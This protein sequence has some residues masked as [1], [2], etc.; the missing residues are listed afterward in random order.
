MRES[1]FK[2]RFRMDE[3]QIKGPSRELARLQTDKERIDAENK[4]WMGNL[5]NFDNQPVCTFCGKTFERRAVLTSHMNNC[6]KLKT[7][8][9]TKKTDLNKIKEKLNQ[10]DET[11]TNSNDSNLNKE[12]LIENI[13]ISE[14]NSCEIVEPVVI[15]KSIKIETET[16]SRKRKRNKT[17][18]IVFPSPYE[19]EEEAYWSLDETGTL[20]V[21]KFIKE[22]V[23]PIEKVETKVPVQKKDTKIKQPKDEENEI[24]CIICD[25]K[26]GGLSN[27]KRHV[28]MFHYRQKKFACK[29]CEYRNFRKFDIIYH[30]QNTHAMNQE[31][32]ELNEFIIE[33]NDEESKEDEEKKEIILNDV[34]KDLELKKEIEKKRKEIPIK[35]PVRQKRKYVRKSLPIKPEIV[36]VKEIVKTIIP[37]KVEEP[38]PP[39]Q[40]KPTTEFSPPSSESGSKRPIRNRIKAIDKDFVYDLSNLLKKD[41]DLF[42]EHQNYA[43]AQSIKTHRQRR[44][45]IQ[46]PEESFVKEIKLEKKLVIGAARKMAELTVSRNLAKIKLQKFQTNIPTSNE[47]KPARITHVRHSI[48]TN[49]KSDEQQTHQ[50]RISVDSLTHLKKRRRTLLK[51]PPLPNL[52]SLANFNKNYEENLFKKKTVETVVPPTGLNSFEADKEFL[53]N[54]KKKLYQSNGERISVFQRLAE[55]KNREETSS[56]LFSNSMSSTSSTIVKE[57][58]LI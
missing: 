58:N 22:V 54:V 57:E 20:T 16:K 32:S 3:V 6:R 25:K 28:A 7:T 27:L 53:E 13:L 40:I 15:E 34:Q 43:I 17:N 51:S 44:N 23:K 56:S 18:K 19:E 38:P 48:A 50:R 55:N 45:T 46:T 8:T 1:I 10:S 5:E 33:L 14:E 30:L 47:L 42:K 24:G 2:R 21:K 9:T 4:A 52:I 35:V 26:F 36:Q 49:F 31:K 11:S 12:I 37:V 29:M 39:P 41:A